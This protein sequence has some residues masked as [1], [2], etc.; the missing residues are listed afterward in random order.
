VEERLSGCEDKVD[1]LSHSD[2]NNKEKINYE[3]NIQDL[4][5]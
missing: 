2:N 4:W 1:E 3:Q 5:A